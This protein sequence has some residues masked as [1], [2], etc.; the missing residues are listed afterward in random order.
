[1]MNLADLSSSSFAYADLS[2]VLLFAANLRGVNLASA[3]LSGSIMVGANLAG[4]DLRGTNLSAVQFTAEGF[5]E[6]S[7]FDVNVDALNMLT[8]DSLRQDA[9]LCGALYDEHTRWP[10][11][12][13]IPPCAINVGQER[14][15]E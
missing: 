12:Y 14:A 2:G 8:R 9:N 1:M 13:I 15:Q 3:D 7:L 4:A 6:S 10:E 5:D 11:N